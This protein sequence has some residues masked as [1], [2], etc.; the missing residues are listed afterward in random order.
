M[1]PRHP[2]P[3]RASGDNVP[4][5]PIRRASRSHNIWADDSGDQQSTGN[6]NGRLLARESNEVVFEHFLDDDEDTVTHAR[7]AS[8]V[9]HDQEGR[10]SFAAKRSMDQLIEKRLVCPDL[11]A[12]DIV[13]IPL[14]SKSAG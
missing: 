7:R 10:D 8:G 4:L 14:R 2:R 9:S 11:A 1:D 12:V 13:K 5:L 6:Q 3:P